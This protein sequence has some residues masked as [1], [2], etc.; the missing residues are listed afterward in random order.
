MGIK[1]MLSF[2]NNNSPN[3]CK[4]THVKSLMN[5]T[6][7][8]DASMLLYQFKIKNK[9][10]SNLFLICTTFRYYNITPIFVFDGKPPKSKESSIE[11]RKA[12]KE[13]F[14]KEYKDIEQ[15]LNNNRDNEMENTTSQSDSELNKK[16]NI[17]KSKC[18]YIT[19]VD[20]ENVKQLFNLYGIHWVQSVGEADIVCAYLMKQDVYAV[21]SDDT[22]M[23]GFGCK[24]VIRSYNITTNTFDMYSLSRILNDTELSQHDFS[25]LCSLCKTDYHNVDLVGEK[26]KISNM[27][28]E[29]EKFKSLKQSEIQEPQEIKKIYSESTS[30]YHNIFDLK[31]YDKET[32][33]HI[34]VNVPDLKNMSF[35]K[36]N[37]VQFLK[38]FNFY[39][40]SSP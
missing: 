40:V 12:K 1:K 7:V 28:V 16:M 5:K 4:N 10:I 39:M 19:K 2:I 34:N 36:R 31:C 35:K 32:N 33:I 29:Y 11:M 20:I 23:F 18:T 9:L 24:N 26:P 15:Q 8:I 21:I 38:R 6:I 13:K 3:S 17:L 30:D 27:N 37:V 22:D 14:Y 25:Y